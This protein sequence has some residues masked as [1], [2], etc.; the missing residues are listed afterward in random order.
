MR[1]IKLKLDVT[2]K[3]INGVPVVFVFQQVVYDKI[4]DKPLWPRVRKYL[5]LK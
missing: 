5:G 1:E 4:K 3:E 2:Q